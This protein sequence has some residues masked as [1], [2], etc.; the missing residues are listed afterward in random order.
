MNVLVDMLLAV[1][2]IALALGA[3]TEFQIG[4]L[5]IRLAA[6][7]AFVQ[8]RHLLPG[9]GLEAAAAGIPYDDFCALIIEKSLEKYN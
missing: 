9:S 4:I 8:V 5:R 2:V 1:A 7:G 3:V 6:D